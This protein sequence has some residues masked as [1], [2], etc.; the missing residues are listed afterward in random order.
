MKNGKITTGVRRF[1]ASDQVHLILR[2]S[3][4]DTCTEWAFPALETMSWTFFWGQVAKAA[5]QAVLHAEGGPNL[6]AAIRTEAASVKAAL[7]QADSARADLVAELREAHAE[8]EQA[9]QTIS[10]IQARLKSRNARVKFL[11]DRVR[12]RDQKVDRAE[13]QKP[14]DNSPLEP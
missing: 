1:T 11:V 2:L 13:P 12:S 9:E 3:V 10:V 6:L 7:A 14:S 4:A 5:A 8:I